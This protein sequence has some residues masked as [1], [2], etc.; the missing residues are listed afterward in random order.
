MELLYDIIKSAVVPYKNVLSPHFT[1]V[2]MEMCTIC[3][4]YSD[5]IRS[6]SDNRQGTIW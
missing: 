4:F 3:I 1:T 2:T 5:S 6:D